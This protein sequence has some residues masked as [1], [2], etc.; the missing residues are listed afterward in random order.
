MDFAAVFLT[1]S[2]LTLIVTK[3]VDTVR[4]AVDPDARFPKVTWNVLAFVVGIAFCIGWEKNLTADLFRM[5][6]A[7]ARDADGL[8]GLSGQ[9]V[10]GLMLGGFAGF[11]HELLDR[12]SP[13]TTTLEATGVDSI[14]ASTTG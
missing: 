10:S 9:V 6:P 4:N 7:L 14:S 5:V 11:G 1:I 8:G 3:V 2:G 13:K 12:L